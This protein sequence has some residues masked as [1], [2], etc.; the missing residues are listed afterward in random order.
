M[1]SV[2]QSA[3]R[4]GFSLVEVMAAIGIFAFC[5]VSIVYMLGTA[6]SSSR[7]SARDSSLAAALHGVDAA[8]RTI[9]PSTLNPTIITSGTSF[10]F[11]L[12]GNMLTSGT[13]SNVYYVANVQAVNQN[14]VSNL[15]GISSGTF[16]AA[17]VT[18]NQQRQFLWMVT[19][20]Y[21]PPNYPLSTTL[22]IG[23]ASYDSTP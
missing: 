14:A 4:S 1:A 22:L 20:S 3:Q 9:P 21:P 19:F 2:A 23:Q 11:D 12:F 7:D 15:T 5:V 6:L 10:Y 18:Q 13:A 17:Q 16:T 8:M